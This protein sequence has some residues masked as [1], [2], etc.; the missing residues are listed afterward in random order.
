[1]VGIGLLVLRVAVGLTM[2][3]HGAQKLMGWFGGPGING[4]ADHLAKLNLRPARFWAW[5]AALAELAGGLAVALG[6]LTPLAS[7]LV[8]GSMLV[9]IATVHLEKGFWNSQGGIEFPLLILA[10]MVALGL[11]GPG[12]Y[13]VDGLLGIQVPAPITD[14][15]AILVVITGLL[16]AIDSRRGKRRVSSSPQAA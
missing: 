15:A 7:L 11:T 4:F 16:V 5:V 12:V 14:A 2:A 1:M 6:I 10:T 13:S 9:A 8:I 3:A